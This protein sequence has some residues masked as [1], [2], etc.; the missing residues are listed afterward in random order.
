MLLKM[1]YRE[2][3][4]GSTIELGED[5]MLTV[6]ALDGSSLSFQYEHCFGPKS[7]QSEVF[8]DLVHPLLTKALEGYNACLFS[9]GQTGSGK[10]YR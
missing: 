2:K 7:N 9:Y 10:T 1:I 3:S 8:R 6:E 4:E 5:G